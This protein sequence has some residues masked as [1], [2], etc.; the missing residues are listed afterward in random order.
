MFIKDKIRFLTIAIHT[1]QLV[2]RGL[3]LFLIGIDIE[4]G[5][6]LR[7]RQ[8]PCFQGLIFLSP[9]SLQRCVGLRYI[10]YR[11]TRFF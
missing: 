5:V 1:P 3:P 8:H 7:H 10:R 9:F 2:E 4:R 6:L 11:M